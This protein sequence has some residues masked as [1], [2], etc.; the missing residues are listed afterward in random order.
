MIYLGVSMFI[1]LLANHITFEQYSEFWFLTYIAETIK[2]ILF[3]VAIV[4]YAK[5]NKLKS[6]KKNIPYLDF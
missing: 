2:N 6:N 3:S 4:V 1:Y 5:N